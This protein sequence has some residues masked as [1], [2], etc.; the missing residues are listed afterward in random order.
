MTHNYKRRYEMRFKIIESEENIE[1]LKKED[2]E[3]I[4]KIKNIIL[5]KLEERIKKNEW[6]KASYFIEWIV[7]PEISLRR[8]P[9]S[10]PEE[11]YLTEKALS[12]LEMKK[13]IKVKKICLGGDYYQKGEKLPIKLRRKLS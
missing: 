1:N 4:K 8:S 6:I 2:E 9:L 7:S 12:E 11:H 13:E 3:M 5:E 10:G